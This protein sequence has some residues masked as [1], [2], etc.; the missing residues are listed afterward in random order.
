MALV[1][2]EDVMGLLEEFHRMAGRGTCE[3]EDQVR[4]SWPGWKGGI[5]VGSLSGENRG[6]QG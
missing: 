5:W 6:A 4:C 3:V 2:W 1:P